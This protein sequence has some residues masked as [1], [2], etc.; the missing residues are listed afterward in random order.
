MTDAFD[1]ELVVDEMPM[2]FEWQLYIATRENDHDIA[3]GL[4]MDGFGLDLLEAHR[5]RARIYD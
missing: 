5:R 4:P 3:S 2:P 1:I